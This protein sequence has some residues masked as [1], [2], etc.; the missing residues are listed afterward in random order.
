[1]ANAV[2]A[3]FHSGVWRIVAQV[4]AWLFSSHRRLPDGSD[5]AVFNAPKRHAR[6]TACWS[7]R[8]RLLVENAWLSYF[9][10]IVG[11][12]ISTCPRN[13]NQKKGCAGFIFLSQH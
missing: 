8:S 10:Q 11:S 4:A 6:Y 13:V 5:C 3:G 7:K 9:A 2:C 1:M 12:M